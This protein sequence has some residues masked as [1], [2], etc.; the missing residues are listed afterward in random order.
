[1]NV[2]YEI[3]KKIAF[4]VRDIENSKWRLQN[5]IRKQNTVL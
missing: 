1:M 4:F 5:A 2:S 3:E